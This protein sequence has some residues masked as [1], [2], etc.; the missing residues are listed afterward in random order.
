V[1]V[2]T[3]P[4]FFSLHPSLFPEALQAQSRTLACWKWKIVDAASGQH[5]ACHLCLPLSLVL[6]SHPSPVLNT[7]TNK[8]RRR[9]QSKGAVWFPL[10]S[11]CCSRRRR[12][13]PP[14]PHV[15]GT[16]SFITCFLFISLIL[17]DNSSVARL[18][19]S[20]HFSVRVCVVPWARRPWH[21]VARFASPTKLVVRLQ[22]GSRPHF[23]Y[24]WM[25]VAPTIAPS[26]YNLPLRARLIANS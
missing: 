8:E 10:P 11:E 25:L 6:S 12:G 3:C 16:H 2:P 26:Y 23:V 7:L 15:L 17:D 21:E 13:R 1:F 9:S 18:A 4:S 14:H 20:K 24:L 19:S 5:L 22:L